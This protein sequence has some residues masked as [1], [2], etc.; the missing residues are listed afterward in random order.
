[1]TR[2]YSASNIKYV[3]FILL[4]FIYSTKTL[5]FSLSIE[6]DGIL[7][8]M[9]VF[10]NLTIIILCVFTY[11]F[12][13]KLSY[14]LLFIALIF[15]TLV[16]SLQGNHNF[17]NYILTISL[18]A[19]SSQI[20]WIKLVE[21]IFYIYLFN[22]LI[23]II[24]SIFSKYYYLADT[25]FGLR[26]TAGF[27]NPN[28][29]S[30]YIL[31]LFCISMMY[32]ESLKISKGILAFISILIGITS[33]ILIYL[34]FSRTGIFLLILLLGSYL[35]SLLFKESRKLTYRKLITF[36]IY[37]LLALIITIQI[38]STLLFKDSII[39]QELNYILSERVRY[40]YSFYRNVSFPPLFGMNIDK[41]LPI[42]FY[43]M[44]AIYSI[45]II[46]FSL[47]SFFV[48]SKIKNIKITLFM[49]FSL[50]IFM[51][52]MLTENYF[53][54]LF[55]SPALFIIFH[56]DVNI[57]DKNNSYEKHTTS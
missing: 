26:F 16:S 19:L 35:F 34:S 7:E 36:L 5:I 29:F 25:R 32:L 9:K 37:L 20:R 38:T 8:N 12:I 50:L 48:L 45:G 4:Y 46:P 41:Y 14:R 39:I 49:G 21:S 42:D 52:L 15:I 31:C 10:L 18:L 53:S 55:Y 40:A 43:F 57:I 24:F 47:L 2:P 51:V 11:F 22:I 3:Y 54:V 17:F 44:N 56:K 6:P 28:T 23:L 27:E 1:M 33:F 13:P 30:L